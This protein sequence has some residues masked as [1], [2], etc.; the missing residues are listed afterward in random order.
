[1]STTCAFTGPATSAGASE[2]A[3]RPVL[4]AGCSSTALSPRYSWRWRTISA[5]ESSDG[6][7]V[8]EAEELRL[9]RRILHRPF[10]Q[11]GVGALLGEDAGRRVR[12]PS[13][14]RAFRPWRGRA[15]SSAGSTGR[16]PVG[17]SGREGGALGV[18]MLGGLR[19]GRGAVVSRHCA[20]MSAVGKDG[21]PL[22]HGRVIPLAAAAILWQ[23][24]QAPHTSSTT[25][26]A[27]PRT[28]LRLCAP[29]PCSAHER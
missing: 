3:A 2:A 6:Q 10:H 1:M 19:M 11:A 16:N 23:E 21:R 7:H 28:F 5:E 22:M 17:G 4:R 13:A 18:A 26:A 8:H 25:A 20:R 12:R 24:S 9:E 14:R 29:G 27:D 15:V